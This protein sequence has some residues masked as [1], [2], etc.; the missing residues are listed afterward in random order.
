MKKFLFFSLLCFVFVFLTNTTYAQKPGDPKGCC[1]YLEQIDPKQIVLPAGVGSGELLEGAKYNLNPII[2]GVNDGKVEYYYFRFI[3]CTGDPKARLSIDWEFLV[4]GANFDK[5]LDAVATNPRNLMNVEIEWKLPLINSEKFQGSG[6]LLSGMGLQAAELYK[7]VSG[8]KRAVRTDFPGTIDGDASNGAGALY[9]YFN[10]YNAQTR[11]YNYIYADFLEWACAHD[12]LRIK[13]TR[14]SD[15]DVKAHFKLLQRTGGVEY[16]ETYD[17]ELQNDYMGGHAAMNPLQIGDFWL[18]GLEVVAGDST[19][20]CSGESVT[21]NDPV[22]GTTTETFYPTIPDPPVV[23]KLGVPS[24]NGDYTCVDYVDT[25]V[26]ENIIWKPAPGAPVKDSVTLCRPGLTDLIASD[27]YKNDYPSWE[28]NWYLD[29]NLTIKLYTGDTLTVLASYYDTDM[30][31]Y[32]TSTVD[33]CEG[34][35]TRY[36]VKVLPELILSATITTPIACYGGLA[37]V[38]VSAT[39]GTP[40]YTGIGDFPVLAGTHDFIVTDDEGCSDTV[41]IIVTEPDPLVAISEILPADSV[42]CFGETATVT[43]SATGGTAPYTGEGRFPVTAGIHQFI[44]TDAHGCK[45]TTEITV[46]EPVKLVASSKILLADS[47]KCFGETATVTISATGGTAPYT[48]IGTF[49]RPA[50]THKF[51]VT[52]AK[53]CVDSTTITVTEPTK[54]VASST[55][56]PTDSIKCF[57]ET[58]TITISATGGTPPYTG[59]GT[60]KRP[61]GGPYK[62]F[63]TDAKGCVDSTVITVAQLLTKLV[64]KAEILPADSIK[65]FGEKA[66]VTVSATGG[67]P[68]YTGIGTFEKTAGTYKFYVTDAHG[69]IDSTQ[70][71]VTQPTLLVASSTILANDSIK[72]FGETAIVTVSAT[73]GTKPYTGVGRFPVT[74][75][76]HRFIVTD[77]KGCID[78]TTI[79]VTEPTKLV[80]SSK[81]LATDSI[82]CFGETATVTISATGGTAPYTG[83]GTFAKP[84][85]HYKFY[86]T[87]AKGCIDSTEITVTEPTKLVAS[88]VVIGAVSCTGDTAIVRVS[89]TG[90]TPPYQGI[91]TFKVKAGTHK[92]P[93]QDAKGCKDTTQIIVSE[94]Q[95]LAAVAV[96][97][98]TDSIFC[99]GDSAIITVNVTGGT[100][101]FTYYYGHETFNKKIKLPV[102]KYA[103]KVI[104]GNLCETITDTITVTQP[105][106][107]TAI[108]TAAGRILCHGDSTIITVTPSGGTPPYT[109][110]YG[111][112][113]FNGT[114][115]LPAGTYDLKVVDHNLCEAIAHI[116]ITEPTKLVA[117]SVIKVTDSVPCYGGFATITVSA[118]GGT[119]PYSGEGRFERPFGGPYQFTVTDANG[120]E[121]IT[122]ISVTTQPDTLTAVANEIAGILCY[123]DSATITVTPT[124]GTLPYTYFY[125]ATSFNGTIKLPAGTHEFT[126]V[127]K[128]GCEATAEITVDQPDELILNAYASEILCYGDSATITVSADGGTG[129]YTYYYDNATFGGT[130]KLPAGTHEFTVTDDNNCEATKILTVTEPDELIA[131]AVIA[132]TDSIACYGGLATITVTATG[133]TPPY[134]GEGKFDRPSGGPY[135]FIVTDANGCESKATISVTQ[136]DTLIVSA[137]TV[138]PIVCQ[139][140][141][142]VIEISVLGGLPPY[143]YIYDGKEFDKT[144]E[145][146]KGDYIF[147]VVDRRG[148]SDTA[149]ISITNYPDSVVITATKGCTDNFIT[150]EVTCTENATVTIQGYDAE[151]GAPISALVVTLPVLAAT[152]AN[153]VF[154]G[155]SG[156]ANFIYFIATAVGINCEYNSAS[157]DTINFNNK[158]LLYV[159]EKSYPGGDRL[160]NDMNAFTNQVVTHY[161]M[162]EDFC[163][164]KKN[165]HL[166]VEYKYYYQET[167]SSP[168]IEVTPITNYLYTPPSGTYYMHF[169]TPMEDCGGPGANVNYNRISDDSYFPYQAPVGSGWYYQNQQYSFFKLT[170]LDERQI[171]V[172][173]SGFTQKGIYTVEY[174]LV[175]HHTAGT[176]NGL[177]GNAISGVVCGSIIGGNN[178]YTITPG[179][180]REVLATRTMFIRVTTPGGG[181]TLSIPETKVASATVYPNPAT[182]NIKIK[183]NNIEGTTNVRIVNVNGILVLNQ[184]I[185]VVQNQDVTI[186]TSDLTPGIYFVNIVSNDAVLTRK[187]VI[188]PK[189]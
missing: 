78:A 36:V 152:P 42:K 132:A 189:F 50:G 73:G 123:G 97:A 102:G 134:T 137:T 72:C 5:P 79:T 33:G 162:V 46:T 9:G 167:E 86:V 95:P 6:P 13:I 103:F 143:T 99:H 139:D 90:G 88:S 67:T 149:M 19:T 70:I 71:T 177:Y 164:T 1:F 82:K 158:P 12:F 15:L 129:N 179:Y 163:K 107:L 7:T 172:D 84:A 147:T 92:F 37:T 116:V 144:I 125:G 57:G 175:T 176:T 22:H 186:K 29:R 183:F 106:L 112:E 105:P 173:I 118:T 113:A 109:Y 32:V 54:L 45:D 69:C 117:S 41:T 93:V 104:D 52:D 110:F 53:G 38:T 182:D 75:G 127:D 155:Y 16:K 26:V 180:D 76:T 124:G 27:P 154:V 108:A 89:A 47:V 20:V 65:C 3:N 77:A 83:I 170:F 28:F 119:P 121:A 171:K 98:A 157:T 153:Y 49:A 150:V 133:G 43:I 161:F 39:G 44:V 151:T 156:T 24:Y 85:G 160:D 168:K 181:G 30:P 166:S 4:G 131:S 64:A 2:A 111:A 74:A 35:A 120:C 114:I 126:V 138:T 60:F 96:I 34:P 87:D 68:P 11:W 61:A 81:I 178:F 91:G 136:P 128:H 17:F 101:P 146:P 184:Q 56:L 174:E 169:T 31:F 135:Q 23:L 10:P 40:P 148:C 62:F 141:V 142:A 21:F 63:V 140:S 58:A 165:I 18:E 25:V 145:L 159:Y 187:L 188:S 94:P 100:L 8:V 59:I 115:K 185:N 80:A 14:Y 48:G 51:Y 130:I 66:T 55:I 122:T